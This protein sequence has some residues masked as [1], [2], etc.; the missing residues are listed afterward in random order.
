M[1]P[2]RVTML[3]AATAAAYSQ[4]ITPGQSKSPRTFQAEGSTT[5]GAGAAQLKLWGSNLQNPSVASTADWAL[6]ATIDLTL[7][8]T[9]AGGGAAI[10][11]SWTHLMVEVV[12]ISGTG[13]SVN[14][15]LG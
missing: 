15:Y 13:A 11:S 12:S 9:K 2:N 3:S 5:A 8:T 4:R 1:N 6:L 10:D 7:A 14:A